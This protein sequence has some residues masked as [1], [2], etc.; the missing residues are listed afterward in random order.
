MNRRSPLRRAGILAVSAA[1]Y[2]ARRAAQTFRQWRG[3]PTPGRC[4]ILYYHSIKNWEAKKFARQLDLLLKIATPVAAGETRGL[5]PN[6][7][8]FAITFDDAFVSVLEKAL[9]EILKRNIPC[10]IFVPSA[11]LGRIPAWRADNRFRDEWETVASA[12]QLKKL[13]PKLVTIGSHSLTHS[14]L[15]ELPQHDV[16]WELTESRAH[17]ENVL[18]RRVTLMAFPYGQF[19]RT[20]LELAAKAGYERVFGTS[21]RTAAMTAAEFVADRIPGHPGDWACE[22]RLKVYGAYSWQS[23]LS[24]VKQKLLAFARAWQK[25]TPPGDVLEANDQP[26][27]PARTADSGRLVLNAGERGRP[28][29]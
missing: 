29:Q 14:H 9:P 24:H 2:A 28:R 18:E 17:L 16:E 21:S 13:N 27:P 23:P 12:D 15:G 1:V 26:F 10:T 4:G 20:H 11:F 5:E 7:H 3:H 22:V 8:Y 25:R 6:R 19:T